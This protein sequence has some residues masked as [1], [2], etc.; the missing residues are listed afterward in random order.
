VRCVFSS[1]SAPLTL[2]V[3]SQTSSWRAVVRVL[4]SPV[5]TL[6][7]VLFP[8]PCCACGSPLLRF[9]RVPV[10]DACWNSLETPPSLSCSLCGEDLGLGSAFVR[11]P[12]ATQSA[13]DAAGLAPAAMKTATPISTRAQA[14]R[15]LTC[16]LCSKVSP[17][18]RRAVAFGTYRTTLRALVHSLKYEGMLPIAD[19]LGRRLARSILSLEPQ[20]REAM[21]AITPRA[22]ESQMSLRGMSSTGMGVA[23][24]LVVPVPPHGSNRRFNHAERIASAAIRELGALRP[25]WKLTLAPNLLERQRV[26]ESQAGLTPHQRRVNV[27]GAFRT[28]H[29][30]ALEGAHVL[31]IDDIYTTGATAR[32]CTKALLKSGAA[33]VWVATVARAQFEHI[34]R[35]R[36]TMF[37]EEAEDDMGVVTV[38]LPMQEDV[39]FWDSPAGKQPTVH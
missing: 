14:T 1:Q 29:P 13:N 4:R 15:E 24:M 30:D 27:R 18:F 16:H 36:P 22:V 2:D 9:S 28:P 8:A 31:L 7:C 33:S 37:E 5:D 21:D 20:I 12:A 34:A 19:G 17:P 35:P 38:E 32:A 23:P 11:S 25:E 39:A 26:T 3:P 6:S 10:C